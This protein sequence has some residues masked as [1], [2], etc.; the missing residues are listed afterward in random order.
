M[1]PLSSANCESGVFRFN[2]SQL[3]RLAIFDDLISVSGVY[4]ARMRVLIRHMAL[5]LKVNYDLIDLY[6]ESVVEYLSVEV[7]EQSK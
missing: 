7:H 6:E 5:L 4:D 3:S 2:E 1:N